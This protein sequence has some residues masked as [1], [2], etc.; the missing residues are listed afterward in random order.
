MSDPQAAELHSIFA[1]IQLPNIIFEEDET[2]TAILCDYKNASNHITNR[3]RMPWKHSNV[4]QHIRKEM[5]PNNK[6]HTTVKG[7]P[8]Q[9]KNKCNDEVDQPAK[10]A[11]TS[12]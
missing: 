2:H 7:I 1:A 9:T 5:V 11:A 3:Y 8:D 12:F 10:I 4:Y 6:D